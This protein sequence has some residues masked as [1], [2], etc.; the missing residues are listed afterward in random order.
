MLLNHCVNRVPWI[1]VQAAGD[2]Q[3]RLAQ[4]HA[5]TSFPGGGGNACLSGP[6]QEA[7]P[8]AKEHFLQAS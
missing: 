5:L 4:L 6:S 1:P 2:A 3:W 7:A 8:K